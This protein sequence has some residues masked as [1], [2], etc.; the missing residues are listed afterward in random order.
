MVKQRYRKNKENKFD[1]LSTINCEE[2]SEE[3]VKEEIEKEEESIGQDNFG[4]QFACGFDI[5]SSVIGIAILDINGE[6]I[7]LEHVKLD[8]IKNI[9]TKTDYFVNEF[10]L[11]LNKLNLKKEKLKNVFVEEN[12]KMFMQ[13]KSTAQT[14]MLLAKMNALISYSVFKMIGILPTDVNVNTARKLLGLKYDKKDKKKST[15]EKIRIELLKLYPNLPLK[16]HVAK[17]GKNKGQEVLDAEVN[18][19]LDAYILCKS[20]LSG[21]QCKK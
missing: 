6:L 7:S 2:K 16:K 13:G 12:A 9:Y 4:L 11:I 17:T 18:D 3:K 5:S 15:K 14:L 21:K 10:E 19:E 20:Q 8:K 1:E